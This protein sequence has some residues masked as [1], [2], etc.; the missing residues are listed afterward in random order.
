MKWNRKS[1]GVKLWFWFLLFA[2]FIFVALWLLQIVFLQNFYD[3]MA[4]RSIERAAEKIADQIESGSWNDLTDCMT[5]LASDESLLIFLTDRNGSILFSAD[6][7]HSVYENEKRMQSPTAG[8]DNPYRTTDD[9]MNW[10][11]GAFRNL[12]TAYDAFLQ[13]LLNS[14]TD[15]IGYRTENG[16]AYI[17]GLRFPSVEA[18]GEAE[19]VLY[20]SMPLGGVGAATGILRLQLIWVTFASLVLGFILAYFISRQ[21]AK[22]IASISAQAG[23]MV[24]GS[25]TE[26]D[27]DY[28]KGFCLELDELSDTLAETASSLKRLE[29]ARR[30][31]LANVSHDL[32]TPLTMIKGY[33]EMIREISWSDEVRREK[34]LDIIIREADR[35]TGL[36]NDILEYSALSSAEETKSHPK[37]SGYFNLST[38]MCAVTEQFAPLCEQKGWSIETPIPP[39]QWVYGEEE[40]IKRVLYNLID[41]AL[42]HSGDCTKIRVTLWRQENEGLVRAEIRD[43]GKGI[44]K[45]ELPSI[46]ERYFTEKKRSRNGTGSGLGLAITREILRSQNAS[47]GVESEPGQGSTFWFA[48]SVR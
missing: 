41:N 23:R 32:R 12:P 19:A 39:D 8:E 34:D 36:V 22:P 1:F 3:G 2:A 28:K 11:L 44:P 45:E 30:E 24:D 47:F 43:Y 9:T 25:L 48:L 4:I 26:D 14:E 33:A 38:A 42:S 29:N 7:H 18:L 31:L 27:S 6:E 35:L 17:Y 20:L 13:K 10:Q 37:D 16:D 46:W 21:F 5:E 15:S 40:S